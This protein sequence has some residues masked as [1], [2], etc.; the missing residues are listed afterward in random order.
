VSDA[1]AQSS[2]PLLRYAPPANATQV[3]MGMPADYSF[4]GFNASLQVYQFRP[5]TGDIR[6]AFQTNLLRDWISPRYQEQNVGGTP[7]FAAPA[8]PGADFAL[9]VAF[10]E[11][12]YVRYRWRAV[13]VSGNY[14]AILD[15]SS[16]AQQSFAALSQSLD[17]LGGSLRIETARAPAALTTADGRAVAGLYRGTAMRVTV[18]TIGG[19][20]YRTPALLFYLLSADGRVYRRYDFP[21]VEAASIAAFDFDAAEMSDR[22]NSGRYAI[23]GGRLIIRMG[24]QQPDIVTV[25]PRNGVLTIDQVDYQRQ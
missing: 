12:G 3:G 8:I 18:N 17:V 5:F 7:Q 15:A 13:I 25:P 21:P 1:A 4:N 19:T 11:T 24:D 6:Q 2:V 9:T 20:L 22:P 10:L 23:E 14:A 16:G